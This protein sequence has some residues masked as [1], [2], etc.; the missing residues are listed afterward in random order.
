MNRKLM[1]R[2][3]ASGIAI[4]GAPLGALSVESAPIAIQ[5]QPEFPLSAA[6]SKPAISPASA[7]SRQEPKKNKSKRSAPK[8]K[9]VIVESLT[10]EEATARAADPKAPSGALIVK[11]LEGKGPPLNR[12]SS[13]PP[14]ASS[15]Q[16]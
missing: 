4:A 1:W 5:P 11:P 12:P 3:A 10:P 13:T 2:A 16:Q 9:P 6:P 14:D 8:P 7:P 15:Q